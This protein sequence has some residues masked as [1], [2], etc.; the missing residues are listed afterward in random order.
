MPD[1]Q[2]RIKAS[3][4]EQTIVEADHITLDT[5]LFGDLGVAGDDGLELMAAFGQEFGV[6]LSEFNA[7]RHFGPEAPG[8]LAFLFPYYW[9]R[10]L[11][12]EAHKAAGVVPISIA[13]LVEAA[14][15]GKWRE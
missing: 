14:R 5:T 11:F 4:A 2:E 8:C 1:L 13:D 3:V 9:L 10:A 15:Q 6:D 12:Y 7:D